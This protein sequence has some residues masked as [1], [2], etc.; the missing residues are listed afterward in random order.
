MQPSEKGTAYQLAEETAYSS[1]GHFK[2]ADWMGI[3]VSVYIFVPLLT[4]I[5]TL[6]FMLPDVAQRIISFVGFLFSLIALMSI[7][8][9]NR[10][11]CAQAIKQHRDLANRYLEIHKQIRTQILSGQPVSADQVKGFQNSISQLDS[12]SSEYPIGLGGRIWSRMRI[13]RE[14]DLGWI[15]K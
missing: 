5:V 15:Y 6:I 4:S 7:W 3:S 2:T 8:T 11:K 10:E 9:N 13:N 1:K 12:E 14:M